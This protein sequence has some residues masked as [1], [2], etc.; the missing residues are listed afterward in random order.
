[1]KY[2]LLVYETPEL[3]ELR[4]QYDRSEPMLA[5]WRTYY[6]SL[7]ESGVYVGGDPLHPPDTGTTVR[8]RNGRRDIQDGPY[9]NT[10]EQLAGFMV[11]E[12]PSLDAAI[13]WAAR[14][15]AAAVGALE[16]RPLAE[17]VKETIEGR[18]A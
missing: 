17:T 16:V 15:P 3:F 10:K 6:R 8:I 2:A 4:Q 11:L 7:V 18:S 14:C 12:L 13:E 9:A 1:M 5:A